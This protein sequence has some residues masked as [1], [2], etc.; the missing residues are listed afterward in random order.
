MLGR[1]ENDTQF[2]R[3]TW[4]P[5]NGFSDTWPIL[6]AVSSAHQDWWEGDSSSSSSST[7]FAKYELIH[8]RYMQN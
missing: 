1:R 6:A 8:N 4:R 5:S 2:D 3:P 7:L